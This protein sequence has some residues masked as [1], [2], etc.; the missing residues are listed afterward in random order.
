MR[1]RGDNSLDMRKVRRAP[2]RPVDPVAINPRRVTGR[3]VGHFKM[4]DRS[5]QKDMDKISIP[6]TANLEE[7]KDAACSIWLQYLLGRM[8]AKDMVDWAVGCLE[9][10]IE[11][12]P[13][14]LLAGADFEPDAE[15][16][17]LFRNSAESVS[18]H[19]PEENAGDVREWMAREICKNIISGKTGEMTGLKQM[20]ALWLEAGMGEQFCNWMYL[21]DSI[22]LINDGYKGIGPF[23]DITKE[24][25]CSTIRKEAEATARDIG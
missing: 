13:I 3:T 24:S 4:C 5:E 2:T 16:R 12:D 10:A 23:A 17:R 14:V 8:I 19:L 20:Y 15:V 1:A 25:I 11:T 18:V 9:V 21:D 7:L 6:A 22:D